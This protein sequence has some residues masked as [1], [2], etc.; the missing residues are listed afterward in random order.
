MENPLRI[1]LLEDMAEDAGLVEY[2]LKKAGIAFVS[3]RVEEKEEFIDAVEKFSPDV[4]LSDHSLPQFNSREALKI[5]R[6]KKLE[7]PFIL[8]TGT[9][10]EEFAVESLKQGADDY[11]LKSN[12]TRLPSAILNSLKQKE[13]E[14]NKKTAETALLQQNLELTKINQELDR[15]VY[16]ASH[17]LRAPL[18]SVLGLVKLSMEDCE[19]QKFDQFGEYLQ[20]M[21]KSILKLDLT[22]KDIINYS[23]NARTEI[24]KEE[25]HFSELID[26]VIDDIK[27][28]KGSENIEKRISINEPVPL[29][30][31]QGRL[32]VV[33]NNI[34]S[35]SIKYHREQA[36]AFVSIDV[37]VDTLRAAITIKDNGIGIEE[38]YL[39]KIF[40]MFYRATAQSEGSGLGLYIVKETIDKL[41]GTIK[42]ES[43]Y[44]QGTTFLIEIP[45]YYLTR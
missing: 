26:C 20:M 43:V 21:E 38:T 27:Y 37:K 41:N 45:N 40:Q 35:N 36:G 3:M 14:K 15:F 30:T 9:V 12:L 25:V 22:I 28:L 34:I 24:I 10:S 11:I 18:K 31:D 19:I 6:E 13:V 1:L 5:C 17:D 16:S 4:V 7:V 23:R 42:V 8:V 39:D 29:Y 44:G 2:V 32:T 33:L